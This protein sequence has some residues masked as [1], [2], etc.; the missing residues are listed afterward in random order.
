MQTAIFLIAFV[1]AFS[2]GFAAFS[3]A[4]RLG[5]TLGPSEDGFT[6]SLKQNA[7]RMERMSQ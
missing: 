4:R 3:W 1:C 2:A 7:S 6:T 5:D